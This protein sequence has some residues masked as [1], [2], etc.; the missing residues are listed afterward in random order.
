MSVATSGAIS[1]KWHLQ[2]KLYNGCLIFYALFV[3]RLSV[4]AVK[5]RLC[6]LL[7]LFNNGLEN[8]VGLGRHYLTSDLNEVWSMAAFSFEP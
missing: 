2:V 7:Y 5:R 1:G 8:Y 4:S 3:R 6:M